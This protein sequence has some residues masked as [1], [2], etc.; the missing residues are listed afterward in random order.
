MSSRFAK[1]CSDGADPLLAAVATGDIS[2]ATELLHAGASASTVANMVKYNPPPHGS[3]SPEIVL[4]LSF[5]LFLAARNDDGNMCQLLLAFGAQ[6]NQVDKVC[7]ESA[8][9]VAARDN[10]VDAARALLGHPEVDVN[11]AGEYYRPLFYAVRAAKYG[12]G[13]ELLQ[14]FLENDRLDVNCMFDDIEQSPLAYACKHDLTRV[15][16]LVLGDP[17]TEVNRGTPL[18]AACEHGSEKMIDMLL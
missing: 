13:T 4:Y 1:L 18:I 2:S 14:L 11:G 17:R 3:V 15:A 16:E 7:P 6:V 8:L 12:Q 9:I 10:H 5:P